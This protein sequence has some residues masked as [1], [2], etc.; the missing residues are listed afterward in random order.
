[1]V[2][3]WNAVARRGNIDFRAWFNVEREPNRS[4]AVDPSTWLFNGTYIH[5]R[6]FIGRSIYLPVRELER[7]RPDVLVQE[8]ATLSAILGLLLHRASVPRIALRYLPTHESW[9]G[10]TKV[11]E[12]AKSFLFGSVDAIKTAGPEA[13]ASLS[14]YPI[15]VERRFAVAQSIDVE[16][17]AKAKSVP[18]EQRRELRV[19][20]A[21]EGCVFL[22]VGRIWEQKGLGYLLEAFQH[23]KAAGANA[24]LLIIGDGKDEDRY[25]SLGAQIPN[26]V[27]SGFVQKRDLPLY[28][29][30]AD[31]F[32]FPTLGDP[33]GLVIDEAMAAGLPVITSSAAGEIN[34]RVPN[35]KAGFIV[36][37]RDAHA[38]F[39]AMRELS[40][41]EQSR[42]AMAGTAASLALQRSPEK[43]AEDFER[44][45][46]CIMEMPIRKNLATATAKLGGRLLSLL[47]KGSH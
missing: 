1:M 12:L 17:F 28:Y 30:A 8:Y 47:L 40:E 25:R 2:D 13:I 36:P 10:R 5:R 41:N 29:A 7:D 15:P 11:K 27:F 35:E 21:L 20:L 9:F 39:L 4:W 23:L 43:Y 19:E 14:G 24:S 3:R 33:H 16:H 6:E 32:V 37:P 18:K 46:F 38:L 34:V 26:V 44:F 42:L 22:Y 31:V 45:I